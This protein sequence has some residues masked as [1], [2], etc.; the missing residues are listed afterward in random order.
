MIYVEMLGRM[1]NQMF[2]YAHAR[3]IQMKFPDQKI[4]LDFSNFREEDETW[5]NYLQYMNCGKNTVT[6][7]RSLNI[8]QKLV[9]R[10]FY[11]ARSKNT[12]GGGYCS[13]Y[14]IERKWGKILDLF[15]LYIFTNGYFPFQYK[16]TFKNKLLVGFFESDKYFADIKEILKR[17]F[18]V[19]GF[20]DNE[21]VMSIAKEICAYHSIC[22]GV[23]KGDFAAGKNKYYCDLC[24]PSYY[25]RGIQRIKDM[26]AEK[27][28]ISWKW[29]IYIFTDDVQW[30]KEHLELSDEVIYITSS[31]QGK[32][33]P[34]EMLQLMTCFQYYVICNSSYFW[35]GQ[36]LSKAE[37]PFVV[38]PDIWRL[39]DQELYRD[40]YEDHWLLLRPDE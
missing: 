34:W 7:H 23:R 18:Q 5:I 30:A 14:E 32:I 25:I 26:V 20:E 28:P 15:D 22:V 4:G 10:F 8:I 31:V 19:T 29:K 38:A 36:F 6:A 9:L 13:V 35:W 24:E 37:N 33:K 2:S 27:E 17:E 39:S 16:G 21:Y 40:I 1:G 11:Q 12:R 3:R